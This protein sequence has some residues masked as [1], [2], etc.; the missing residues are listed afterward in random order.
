MIT[1]RFLFWTTVL[2]YILHSTCCLVVNLRSF[3]IGERWNV[4]QSVGLGWLGGS[5]LATL[6]GPGLIPFKS[7]SSRSRFVSPKAKVCKVQ[8]QNQVL[9]LGPGLRSR[10]KI[11]TCLPP[12]PGLP[13][14][15]PG[16]PPSLPAMVHSL[17]SSKP[18][19]DTI[20]HSS[21]K[22]RFRGC[23]VIACS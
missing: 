17:Q 22:K 15:G 1:F 21:K 8:F 4:F 5:G 11:Y 7:R 6:Q 10:S 13:G 14:P 16:L 2:F 19:G 12:G 9:G 3:E 20:S 18:S 23:E